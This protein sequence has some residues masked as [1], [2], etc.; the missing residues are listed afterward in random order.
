MFA[1]GAIHHYQLRQREVMDR[2]TAVS[3]RVFKN[4]TES[5]LSIERPF[6]DERSHFFL[7]SF[8]IFLIDACSLAPPGTDT[9]CGGKLPEKLYETAEIRHQALRVAHMALLVKR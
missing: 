9:T 4:P 7:K 5:K 3:I 8:E 1:A 2:V 6:D